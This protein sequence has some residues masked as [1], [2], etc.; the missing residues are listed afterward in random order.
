M[1]SQTV[2]D[3]SQSWLSA[4]SS[5]IYAADASAVADLFLPHGWLRDVLTFTWDL[6]SLEGREKIIHHLSASQALKKARVSDIKLDERNFLQPEEI[7]LPRGERSIEGSFTFETGTGHGQGKMR[8][9]ED[10]KGDWKALY[11]SMILYDLRGYEE[12][13]FESGIYGGH[14]LAWG[15]VFSERKRSVEKDPQVLISK[16]LSFMTRQCTE[17][18][19]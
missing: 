12:A 17:R 7:I 13:G 16:L 9:L 6:R 18:F 15:D 10:E 3:I 5:A 19:L 11:V 14:T 8:L 4:Y 2:T 1:A